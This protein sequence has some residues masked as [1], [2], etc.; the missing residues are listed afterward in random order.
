MDTYNYI[1]PIRTGWYDSIEQQLSEIKLRFEQEDEDR[2]QEELIAHLVI[3]IPRG[4]KI[5]ILSHRHPFTF[6][7]DEN[8]NLTCSFKFSKVILKDDLNPF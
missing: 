4:K 5:L 3:G 8:K 6:K 1:T 2:I 7:V